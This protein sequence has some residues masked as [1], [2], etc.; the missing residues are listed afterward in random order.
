MNKAT[1]DRTINIEITRSPLAPF[2]SDATDGCGAVV[3]FVGIVRGEENGRSITALEYEAYQPMAEREIARLI[4]EL[5]IQFPCE[6]V[7]VAH[8]IGRVPVGEAAIA[9]RVTSRHRAEAF[10]L[11]AGFMDRLKQE[12]PIWKTGVI[13]T[14]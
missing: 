1:M 9:L 2:P 11:T 6:A 10:S 7:R 13:Y 14:S 3:E 8:R 4:G 5:L 12:V